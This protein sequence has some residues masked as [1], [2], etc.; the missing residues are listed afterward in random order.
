MYLVIQAEP[1]LLW[2][3]AIL[4]NEINCRLKLFAAVYAVTLSSCLRQS[5]SVTSIKYILPVPEDIG[6]RFYIIFRMIYGKLTMVHPL[7]D[8]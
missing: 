1:V 5:L 4:A 7:H 3:E 2:C 8:F 6:H